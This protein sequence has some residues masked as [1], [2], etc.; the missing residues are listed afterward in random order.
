MGAAML[1]GRAGLARAMGSSCPW[2]KADLQGKITSAHLSWA[3]RTAV[4]SLIPLMY[5]KRPRNAL[6][7]GLTSQ[8]VQFC[9]IPP[10]KQRDPGTNSSFRVRKNESSWQD[11]ALATKHS[12]SLGLG[13]PSAPRM[14]T[15]IP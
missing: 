12:P 13:G 4:K 11:Q 6:G 5:Q 7:F 1:R 15:R 10:P 3:L 2:S 9:P 14:P 8:V